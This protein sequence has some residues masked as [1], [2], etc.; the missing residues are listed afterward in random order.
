MKMSY[1]TITA[2]YPL[3]MQLVCTASLLRGF[4]GPSQAQGRQ[5]FTSTN[6]ANACRKSKL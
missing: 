6:S 1:L 4:L 3:L 2:A 5:Q